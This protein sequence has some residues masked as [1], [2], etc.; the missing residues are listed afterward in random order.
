[1]KRLLALAGAAALLAGCAHDR[2]SQ[3]QASIHPPESATAPA[4]RRVASTSEAPLPPQG[5]A[6]FENELV[7]V[8]RFKVA[9]GQQVPLP[10]TPDEMLY[11]LQDCRLRLD[12]VDGRSWEVQGKKDQVIWSDAAQRGATATGTQS[13]DF[14]LLEFKRAATGAP[15]QGVQ[16][17]APQGGVETS[18]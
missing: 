15:T 4:P 8:S 13:C 16:T 14:V 12:S 5:Q 17:P 18:P 3:S 2:A 11:P 1:M 7:R 10:S 6:V 9:Q